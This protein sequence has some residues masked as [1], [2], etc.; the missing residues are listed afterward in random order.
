M[1][2]NEVK[3]HDGQNQMT[4]MKICRF[5]M[6]MSTSFPIYC[7]TEN[8]ASASPVVLIMVLTLRVTGMLLINLISEKHK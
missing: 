6:N 7:Y 1:F 2:L 4:P 8:I 5:G 3:Q